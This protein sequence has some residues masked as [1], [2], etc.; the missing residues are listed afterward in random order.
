L[1]EE[2]GI[3]YSLVAAMHLDSVSLESKSLGYGLQG[4]NKEDV[5]SQNRDPMD[6][7][8]PNLPY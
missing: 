2:C 7:D 4:I 1:E 5:I 3:L 8:E 6:I